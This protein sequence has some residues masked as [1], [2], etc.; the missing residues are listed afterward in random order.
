M[1]S[2]TNLLTAPPGLGVWVFHW[3]INLKGALPKNSISE[4]QYPKVFAW[5]NRFDRAIKDAKVAA[6]RPA[7]VRGEEATRRISAAAYAEPQ[8]T[9]DELDPTGLKK[10][11]TVEV[12]PTDSG[13]R[14]RDRGDL[15]AI[16]KEEI[17]VTKDNKSHNQ[18]VRVHFPR[19]NFRVQAVDRP[20]SKL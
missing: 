19:I 5:V 7:T 14:H 3:L 16:N 11:Q 8:A 20:V 17:V 18:A 1:S 12:W 15:L 2:G 9:I 13:I 6:P 10:G 4:K